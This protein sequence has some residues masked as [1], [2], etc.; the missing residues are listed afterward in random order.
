LHKP[1]VHSSGIPAL[2]SPAKKVVSK[3]VRM[4]ATAKNPEVCK[5]AMLE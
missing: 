1:S 3:T 4:V 5:R 2:R